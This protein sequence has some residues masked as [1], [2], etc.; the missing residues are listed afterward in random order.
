M[1]RLQV[2]GGRGAWVGFSFEG[3]ARIVGSFLFRSPGDDVINF[4]FESSQD[5]VTWQPKQT[6]VAAMIR[7]T[8]NG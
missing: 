2:S 5:G 3:D 1:S 7:Q 8:L 6:K 4:V